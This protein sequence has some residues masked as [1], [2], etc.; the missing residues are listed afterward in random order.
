MEASV[1]ATTNVT[2]IADCVLEL[3]SN[4]L[5]ANATSIA[6]RFHN[7]QRKIQVIDNGIGVP[8]IQLKPMA[9]YNNE[10][11]FNCSNIHDLCNWRKRTLSNIRRLSN[12]ML[13]TSRYYNSQKTFMKIFKVNRKPKIVR[14]E[15]RPSQGTTMSIYGFH[16]LSLNKW[17]VPFMYHLVGN[18]AIANPHT[19][20]SIRDDQKKKITMI[21]AKPHKP[22]DVF[23]SLYSQQVSL[24]KVWYTKCTKK[25][26]IKFCVYIG[27]ADSKTAAS[28]YIFVNDK[29]VHCP[30][31][32]QVVSAT[33]IDIL[34]FFR[35]QHYEHTSK[36]E[37]VFI[38]LFIM[39]TNYIFT[40]ENGR[41]TL[42][43]S[44][45][46]DLLQIIRKKILNIFTKN[47]KP[48]SDIGSS[49]R[50][51]EQSFESKEIQLIPNDSVQLF[52][53]ALKHNNNNKESMQLT[54]SEWSNWSL[55][56][57]ENDSLKF[58][59]HFDFLPQ[60]LHKLLR[61]TTKLTKTE[62][63]NE[64]MNG[65][66]CSTKLK[67]GL[68]I[69]D[70]IPH[71]EL[72]VRPCKTVQRFR[73]FTLNKDLLKLIKILGQMNNELIVGLI[74][75]NNV[76]IL[77][78]M[79][80]HAIHERIRYEHLLDGYKIQI[81]NQL[82]SVKLK[83][84]IVI[85]LPA[86]SCNLLLSNNTILKKFGITFNVIENNILMIRAVPECLRKNKYH[87]DELRLK[88]NVKN[89]L[90]EL[91]QNFSHYNS[92]NPINNL[93]L[94][95]QNA[96]ATEACHGAIKFGDSLTL[97]ECKWLL[98][99][100]NKTKIPTQCAHGRPS[101]VP[102][103]ELTDLEKRHKKVIRVRNRSFIHHIY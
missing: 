44:N 3:I 91:L 52:T 94:T 90:N 24:H 59:K 102:L 34:K 33:F 100:L 30:L 53:P 42:M 26:N 99:L 46:Q 95:I 56:Q 39:C 28:Q 18:I 62:V 69:P 85:Q 54:L 4:S 45:I 21:I 92:V 43:F 73:E 37:T 47:I 27:L 98:K 32:L 70:I 20:F 67:S 1:I 55:K 49:N 79:D 75:H 60:K 88:L 57:L 84:P 22:L 38:L 51:T 96:I 5:S 23:K 7:E 86:D 80:Q 8:K 103:L 12:A 14:I 78:L 6:I 31:I 9:E 48:L 83:D 76:K 15:R 40:I 29:L 71:Q 63:L 72:D 61:G 81:R 11:I 64:Y 68:Q 89:L 97:K 17:N 10:S 41:R 58:Y 87:Y 13:I 50:S 36:K 19:S 16:E 35:R 93:P 82:F 25:S 77:L 101:I 2:S 74:I 65:S 66:T